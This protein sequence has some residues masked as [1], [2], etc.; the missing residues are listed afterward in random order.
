MNNDLISI[1][2]DSYF[3]PICALLERLQKFDEIEANG[4]QSGFYVNGFSA[5]ICLLAA[6]CLES[7]TMRVRYLKKSTQAEIDKQS[8]VQYLPKVFS[9][10][11]YSK[12]LIEIFIVRDVVIHNHLWEIGFDWSDNGMDLVNA[13]SKSS[14]DRKYKEQV[15][16][17]L[18]KTKKL[19]LNINPIKIGKVDAMS[20]LRAMWRILVYLQSQ[21]LQFCSV[22]AHHYKYHGK[23][24][25]FGEIVGMPE[26]CT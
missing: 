14:G 12:E 10:F 4:V 6:A 26:T 19:N 22:T 20:V 13:A 7:Y 21:D 18:R 25:R 24:V 15:D 23:L 5:S 11:P 17:N 9:G 16:L 1:I 8:V 2:G 3:E